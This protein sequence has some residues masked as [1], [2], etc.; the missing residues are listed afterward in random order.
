MAINKRGV[1]LGL[2]QWRVFAVIFVSVLTLLFGGSFIGGTVTKN[3]L[4]QIPIWAWIILVIM[5]FFII[6]K[7]K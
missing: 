3:A 5:V 4:T 1:V 2:V 7:R 6:T